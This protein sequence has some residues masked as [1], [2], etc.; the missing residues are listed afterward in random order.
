MAFKK[1]RQVE[2]AV[3]HF[4]L[5]SSKNTISGRRAGRQGCL[6]CDLED[7][8][9]LHFEIPRTRENSIPVQAGVVPV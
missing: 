2:K 9:F 5:N 6:V 8:D 3:I 7:F 1:W 4:F